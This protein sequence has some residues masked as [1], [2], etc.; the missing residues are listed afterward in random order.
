[1]DYSTKLQEVGKNVI[2]WVKN[3][4]S[5][6]LEKGTQVVHAYG[7]YAGGTCN[8]LGQQLMR[9]QSS[10]KR[11][12]GIAGQLSRLLQVHGSYVQHKA[13]TW[14]LIVHA[15]ITYRIMRE[16][17]RYGQHMTGLIFRNKQPIDEQEEV[18]I[19]P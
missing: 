3:S 17:W 10:D 18:I 11:I 15:Y 1:M 5:S 14:Q 13:P 9:Y 2:G 16:T 12:A 7:Y 19:Q 4:D 8:F 6:Y